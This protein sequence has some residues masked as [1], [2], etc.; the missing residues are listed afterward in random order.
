[1]S[2]G[3]GHARTFVREVR[4]LLQGR[5]LQFKCC[6]TDENIV[7]INASIGTLESIT[8]LHEKGKLMDKNVLETQFNCYISKDLTPLTTY[9]ER[10]HL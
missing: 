2:S 4:S 10:S 7:P 1:M 9:V 5:F 3:K 8:S 6:A